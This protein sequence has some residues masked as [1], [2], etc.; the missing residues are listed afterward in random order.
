MTPTRSASDQRSWLARSYWVWRAYHWLIADAVSIQKPTKDRIIYEFL[1]KNLG[2]A[3]DIGSGPGVFTRY[4]CRNARSVHAADIDRGALERLLA[5]HEKEKNLSGVV[6]GAERLPFADAQFDTVL[7]LEVLEHLDDDAAG[8]R[9]IHRILAPG[10]KLVLSVP[11]PPGEVNEGD[12]WGHKREGYE[13]QELQELVTR[14]GF[15]V[16]AFSFAVFKYSRLANRL[17]NRWQR[18]LRLPAPMFLGWASYLDLLLHKK[19]RGEG[20][21]LPACLVVLAKREANAKCI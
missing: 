2:A 14:C 7:F 21:Y 19:G 16:G 15:S 12:P 4:L 9:E 17:V 11:V 1:G 3:A 6:T 5:R 13:L 10:G 18:W 20:K 8:L